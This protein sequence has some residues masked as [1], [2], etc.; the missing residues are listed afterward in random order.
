LLSFVDRPYEGFRDL[1]ARVGE[2]VDAIN[3]EDLVTATAKELARTWQSNLSVGTGI[4]LITA[5]G[6]SRD[7]I[8]R[9]LQAT[10]RWCLAMLGS[11]EDMRGI[12]VIMMHQAL[13]AQPMSERERRRRMRQAIGWLATCS[14]AFYEYEPTSL[15]ATTSLA[16]YEVGHRVEE[17]LLTEQGWRLG[18]RLLKHVKDYPQ[19]NKPAPETG[20]SK[21]LVD[22][23][24]REFHENGPVSPA[25]HIGVL[26]KRILGRLPQV[27]LHARALVEDP[28]NSVAGWRLIEEMSAIEGTDTREEVE[29]MT[30]A[31]AYAGDKEACLR[32][33]A[34]AIGR[35][36]H[37]QKPNPSFVERALGWLAIA[38]GE[39]PVPDGAA[40]GEQ[41]DAAVEAAGEHLV[42]AFKNT[43]ES[44]L[45]ALA[46]AAASKAEEPKSDDQDGPAAGAG[47]G[48]LDVNVDAV[49][50]GEDDNPDLPPLGAAVTTEPE[51]IRPILDIVKLGKDMAKVGPMLG[52]LVRHLPLHTL[53]LDLETV[54]A[55]LLAEFPHAERAVDAFYGD[56][57][58]AQMSGRSVFKIRPTLLV[59]PPGTGK[60]RLARRL[61]EACDAM[62]FVAHSAA[63]VADG[64]FGGMSRG[65]GG[66]HPCLPLLAMRDKRCANPVV[67]LDEVEK[68]GIGKHNGSLWDVLITMIEPETAARWPD[69][70]VQSAVN[71]SWLNW[72]FT[73]NSLSGLPSP[74]LD[75][76]RVIEV[77]APDVEH[78]PALAA[79]VLGEIQGTFTNAAWVPPLDGEEVTVLQENWSAHRSMRVLKTMVEALLAERDRAAVRN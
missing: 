66:S 11:P 50:D 43:Y 23:D 44:K 28:T 32:A 41:V 63:G 35:I 72:V 62:P 7:S 12:A 71:I 56:L 14:G 6:A 47:W 60:S 45:G 53:P 27:H 74:L 48:L 16:G 69:P 79:S 29:A 2:V 5:L 1:P 30:L 20:H 31:L 46:K 24:A 59:G 17:L 61:A 67:L 65:W 52:G 64:M 13:H 22:R 33:A 37:D 25:V 38:S 55:E 34:Y 75:R 68:A 54:R 70:Y 36:Y 76:V 40:Y 8:A 9:P 51:A 19:K 57:A 49:V 42:G 77:P 21:R 58:S 10:V 78:V 18:E 26:A 39:R 4:E 73:A 15:P 3:A